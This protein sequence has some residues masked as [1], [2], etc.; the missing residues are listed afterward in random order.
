MI[1]ISLPQTF[2][3]SKTKFCN[4]KECTLKLKESKL[5]ELTHKMKNWTHKMK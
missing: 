2:T 1:I 4:L 5:K 3:P